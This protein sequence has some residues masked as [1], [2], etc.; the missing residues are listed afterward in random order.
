MFAISDEE[1]KNACT[2]NMVNAMIKKF[3]HE[4]LPSILLLNE[5]NFSQLTNEQR[6]YGH[7]FLDGC[8]S[9]SVLIGAIARGEIACLRDDLEKARKHNLKIKFFDFAFNFILGSMAALIVQ[10]SLK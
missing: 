3:G 7:A 6:E 1:L 4:N 8:S 2:V 10:W 9:A 5:N